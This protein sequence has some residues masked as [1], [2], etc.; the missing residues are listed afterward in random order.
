MRQGRPWLMLLQGL[1]TSQAQGAHDH[2]PG[3]HA[4]MSVPNIARDDEA[5][6]VESHSPQG[7]GHDPD[8][9]PA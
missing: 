9:R 5:L 2:G 8:P 7:Q 1:A 4:P 6:Q 3:S